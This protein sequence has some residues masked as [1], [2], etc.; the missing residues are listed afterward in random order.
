MQTSALMA[1]VMTLVASAHALAQPNFDFHQPIQPPRK[2]QVMVHRGMSCAAPENS[3]IAIEMC[4]QDYC[5]WTEIDVRLSKDGHHVIIHNDTVDAA[6]NGT[7]RVG[8]LTLQDLKKLDAGSWF[9][10]RF[11]SSRLLTLTEALKLANV[12]AKQQKINH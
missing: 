4:A 2:V 3:A 12:N 9:A 10:K 11:A 5:E 7:G 8:D 1:I 6:T